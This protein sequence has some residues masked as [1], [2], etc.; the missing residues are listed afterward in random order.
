MKLSDHL[1]DGG[2]ELQNCLNFFELFPPAQTQVCLFV[3]KQQCF[4]PGVARNLAFRESVPCTR[5]PP[6][7]FLRLFVTILLRSNLLNILRLSRSPEAKLPKPQFDRIRAW[8]QIKYYPFKSWLEFWKL[9]KESSQARSLA[10]RDGWCLKS[11]IWSA[12]SRI[13][14][15]SKAFFSSSSFFSIKLSQTAG[16]LHLQRGY[17][18]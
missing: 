3:H 6:K 8:F 12:S 1:M 17:N 9:A 4:V 10:Q 2:I 15:C 13:L 11:L 7:K 16:F 14:I 5:F 18:G